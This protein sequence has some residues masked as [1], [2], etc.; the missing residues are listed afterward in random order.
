[1]QNSWTGAV[2]TRLRA[3]GATQAELCEASGVTYTTMS[4]A[5]RG[6][7]KPRRQTVDAIERGLLDLER[8]HGVVSVDTR[9][10]SASDSAA[11]ARTIA[12]AVELWYQDP[13]KLTAFNKWLETR[14]MRGQDNGDQH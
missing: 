12:R 5:L 6:H 4:R 2:V 3:A 8:E 11:L 7:T 1:M 10:I 14:E 9:Q 13:D